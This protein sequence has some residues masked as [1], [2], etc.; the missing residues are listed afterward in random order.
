[1][2]TIIQ[3]PEIGNIEL[4]TRNGSRGVSFRVTPEKVRI[5]VSP[6]LS[7]T[8]FPLSKE[9]TE[10]ILNAQQKIATR[11]RVLNFSPETILQT[12]NFT[13]T[14][15]PKD[16]LKTTFAA[17]RKE[18]TLTIYFKP[19]TDFTKAENQLVIKRIVTHF[20]R[21]EAVNF[22][23]NHLKKLAEKYGFDYSK[24]KINSAHKRWGSCSVHK[25]INL[26]LYLMLLP[27]ELIDF[28]I[29]H[30]LCHTREMNHGERFKKLMRTIFPNYDELNQS[31]K[32]QFTL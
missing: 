24:V 13:V 7:G 2:K 17:Q 30:E 22:L 18:N 32:K 20:L 19:E 25:Q 6:M 1:M 5:T 15:A 31:L 23:P 12:H 4:C 8:V 28:I 26:S 16:N 11:S 27:E 10:W 29:V 3:H 14:F 21:I 9:R